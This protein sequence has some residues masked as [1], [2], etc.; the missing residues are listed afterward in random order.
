MKKSLNI[1]GKEISI[2]T[3]NKILKEKRQSVEE[4][5]KLVKTINDEIHISNKFID[6]LMSFNNDIDMLIKI[7]SKF[8]T[9]NYESKLNSIVQSYIDLRDELVYTFMQTRNNVYD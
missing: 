4:F 3:A 9:I 7:N 2:K 1:D 5:L 8:Q 6:I